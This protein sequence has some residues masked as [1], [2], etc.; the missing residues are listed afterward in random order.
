MLVAPAISVQF[1]GSRIACLELRCAQRSHCRSTVGVG[2][3]LQ[4]NADAVNSAP[5]RSEPRIEIELLVLGGAG[6]AG[7]AKT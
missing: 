1:P 3:P 6:G 5:T 4:L 7:G 2:E